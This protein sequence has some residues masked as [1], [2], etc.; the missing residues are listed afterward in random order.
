VHHNLIYSFI[1]RRYTIS[2]L[3]CVLHTLW[4]HTFQ[5]LAFVTICLNASVLHH[6]QNN[7]KSAF[8]K[9]KE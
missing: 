6:L 2:V 3:I 1:Y 4:K 9:R 5:A 8:G 7:K